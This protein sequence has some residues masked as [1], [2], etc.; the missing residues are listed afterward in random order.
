MEWGDLVD[1]KG[2]SGC[3]ENDPTFVCALLIFL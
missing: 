3:E 2:L 1:Q